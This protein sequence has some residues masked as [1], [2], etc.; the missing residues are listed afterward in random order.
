MHK[1]CQRQS[2]AKPI[3]QSKTCFD[4]LLNIEK[5]RINI[6]LQNGRPHTLA[7]K[8]EQISIQK[9]IT[10]ICRT[11][12]F[13]SGSKNCEN[14][15]VLTV[16]YSQTKNCENIYFFGNKMNMYFSSSREEKTQKSPFPMY[17]IKA[18]SV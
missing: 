1:C 18:F 4:Q 15:N 10:C 8:T 7:V 13:C 3:A 6:L 14:K 16:I 17:Y 9:S 12:L 5:G 11:V 2:L